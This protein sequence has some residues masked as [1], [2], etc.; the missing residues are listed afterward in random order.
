MV[1][2]NL[3]PWRQR[4]WQYHRRQALT[5]VS[6]LLSGIVQLV[7]FQAWR[8][9]AATQTALQQQDTLRIALEEVA[10]RLTQQKQAMQ[11]LDMQ[12][13]QLNKQQFQ[14]KQLAIWQQFWL[15]LPALLPDTL[16]LQRLEKRDLQ[17][18]V[19]GHA[20]NMQA[21]RTFRHQLAGQPLFVQVR[22]G[23]VKRQSE[24]I[25]QFSLRAQLQEMANE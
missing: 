3:L 1:A 25:Y 16:W 11:M 5:I 24:G 20:E 21:I 13:K 12:Q 7:S 14:A 22:Q 6:L 17:L 10:Q 15:D 9:Y 8:I 23:S 2:V 18:L 4:R 19:E